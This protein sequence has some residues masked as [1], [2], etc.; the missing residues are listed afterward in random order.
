MIMTFHVPSLA[1]GQGLSDIDRVQ[2]GVTQKK[3]QKR[4]VLVRRIQTD[5]SSNWKTRIIGL[6]LPYQESP[7]LKFFWVTRNYRYRIVPARWLMEAHEMS[8]LLNLPYFK[9]GLV[10]GSL[11]QK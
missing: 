10:P 8:K 5:L 6:I 7:F 3:L 11:V 1:K 9:D 4:R 2:L